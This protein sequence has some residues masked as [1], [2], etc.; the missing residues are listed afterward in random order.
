M[1]LLE[2][3]VAKQLKIT[4]MNYKGIIQDLLLVTVFGGDGDSLQVANVEAADVYLSIISAGLNGA[5]Q[6][7]RLKLVCNET[8]SDYCLECL[9]ARRSWIPIEKYVS[10]FLNGEASKVNNNNN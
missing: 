3:M 7:L 6:I 1:K 10:A 5:F 8:F 9:M 2:E 4:L